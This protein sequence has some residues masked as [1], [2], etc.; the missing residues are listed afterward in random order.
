MVDLSSSDLGS[1][2]RDTEHSARLLPAGERDA[3]DL[4][5]TR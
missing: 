4:D 2:A 5:L 1:M 3:A